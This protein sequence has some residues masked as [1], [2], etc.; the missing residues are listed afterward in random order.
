MLLARRCAVL[1]T[2]P[3][4]VEAEMARSVDTIVCVSAEEAAALRV[5]GA[6][7]PLVVEPWL[8]ELSLTPAGFAERSDVFMVAG[9]L[10]G[11]ESPNIDGL[12]WFVHEVL[13]IVRARVPWVRVRVSG[14]APPKVALDAGGRGIFF[15]G[16]VSDMAEFYGRM[17]ACIVPLRF[18][19]GVKIKTVE[20]LQ[21]G[22]P[23]VATS[24]GA[25]GIDLRGTAALLVADDARDFAHG[26]VSLL[27]DRGLGTPTGRDRGTRRT[28]PIRSDQGHL[29]LYPG[30]SRRRPHGRKAAT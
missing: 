3:A 4:A 1:L 17:R 20:A 14:P 22:V 30:G 11:P 7:E 10:A 26:L 27:T 15:E 16:Q 2:K 24:V 12:L 19:A 29:G 18:G 9:W 6:R 23:T 13:P 8:S 21:Y 25:E 28:A 5:L